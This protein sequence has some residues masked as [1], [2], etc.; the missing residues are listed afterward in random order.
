MRGRKRKMELDCQNVAY[1][2]VL[3]VSIIRGLIV[4]AFSIY[5]DLLVLNSFQLSVW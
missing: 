2:Y 3:H 1:K 5:L 4:I